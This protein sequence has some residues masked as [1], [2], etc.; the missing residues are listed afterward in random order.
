MTAPSA[1]FRMWALTLRTCRVSWE[2]YRPVTE[3]P[4]CSHQGCPWAPA[5]SSQATPD[6]GDLPVR[7]FPQGGPGQTPAIGTH[8]PVVPLTRLPALCPWVSVTV[9]HPCSDTLGGYW[10]SWHCS[11]SV[12]SRYKAVSSSSYKTGQSL[13]EG[14]LYFAGIT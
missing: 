8:A 1:A 2:G 3:C 13:M 7:G 5:L 12:T 6:P 4:V 11:D 14:G 9:W 10:T